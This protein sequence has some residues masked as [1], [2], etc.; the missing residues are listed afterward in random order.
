MFGPSDFGN[1]EYGHFDREGKPL[2][3]WLSFLRNQTKE[4]GLRY[5]RVALYEAPTWY[6]STVRLG[7]SHGVRN[8]KPLI[9]ETMVFIEGH[10]WDQRCWR[11]TT[12]EE[13]LATHHR[14]V[15]LMQN[16]E[17]AEAADRLGANE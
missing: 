17:A 15:A 12:E 16:P 2:E 5:K 7:L 10:P 14:I 6:I 1:L 4:E 13:A 11:D 9:F 8:G 3:N